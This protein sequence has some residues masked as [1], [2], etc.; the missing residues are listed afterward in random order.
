MREEM[1][2]RPHPDIAGVCTRA[3]NAANN[4]RA[5]I[6]RAQAHWQHP[7]VILNIRRQ[8]A[9]WLND[10]SN[11]YFGRLDRYHPRDLDRLAGCLTR[12]ESVIRI[13]PPNLQRVR[14]AIARRLGMLQSEALYE[15]E[16]EAEF[17]DLIYGCTPCVRGWKLCHK[18]IVPDDGSCTYVGWDNWTCRC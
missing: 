4:L 18:S 12:V 10:T 16:G 6:R 2:Y 9:K 11:A 13:T 14:A 17:G 7:S 3:T 5:H 15:D 1:K 8:G